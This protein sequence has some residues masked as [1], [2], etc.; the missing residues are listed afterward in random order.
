MNWTTTELIDDSK[1]VTTASISSSHSGS[2][3]SK[4]EESRVPTHRVTLENLK[5]PKKKNN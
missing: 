4:S 1:D 5:E 3:D 2:S